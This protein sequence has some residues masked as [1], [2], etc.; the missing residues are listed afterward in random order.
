LEEKR[1]KREIEALRLRRGEL[2]YGFV[3][4]GKEIEREEEGAAA[5]QRV[6]G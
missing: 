1:E 3:F 5:R 6:K 2:F 4:I